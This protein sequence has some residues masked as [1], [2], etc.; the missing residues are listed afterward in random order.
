MDRNPREVQDVNSGNYDRQFR[1]SQ[2]MPPAP[3]S[4]NREKSKNHPVIEQRRKN[5]RWPQSGEPYP[6]QYPYPY[7]DNIQSNLSVNPINVI[8][9][10]LHVRFDLAK[11]PK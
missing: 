4:I 7:L 6:E 11:N 8:V 2:K 9:N 10:T 5:H 3:I 1:N